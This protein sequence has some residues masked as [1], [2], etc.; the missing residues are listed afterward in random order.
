M[1]LT[2]ICSTS[3]PPKH[4]LNFSMQVVKVVFKACQECMHNIYAKSEKVMLIITWQS[5]CSRVESPEG[6][7]R[8]AV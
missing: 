7:S 2:L 8:L 1:I 4:S 3:S 6:I 5:S